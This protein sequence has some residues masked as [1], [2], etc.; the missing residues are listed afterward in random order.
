MKTQTTK[1]TPEQI[2]ISNQIILA[3]LSNKPKK[4]IDALTRQQEKLYK[5]KANQKFNLN[6]HTDERT[7][8]SLRTQIRCTSAG[9]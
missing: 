6:T 5:R 3:V 7:N 2:A 8:N 9:N 1:P 4:E